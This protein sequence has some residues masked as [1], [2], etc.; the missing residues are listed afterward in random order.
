VK[1]TLTLRAVPRIGISSDT[2]SIT[3]FRH[4]DADPR[5]V[6]VTNVGTGTLSGL[7]VGQISYAAATTPGWLA[8]SFDSST[9][10]A[11]LTLRAA[12]QALP[13]G[14]FYATVPILSSSNGVADS[15]KLLTVALLVLSPP[16]GLYAVPAQVSLTWRQNDPAGGPWV[17]VAILPTG[18]GIVTHMGFPN[19]PPPYPYLWSQVALG[20]HDTEFTAPCTLQIRPITGSLSPGTYTGV[21][22]VKSFAQNVTVSVPV[23]L[24]VTP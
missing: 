4:N 21:V 20:C 11:H 9:A 14:T 6:L 1:A 16:P 7:S 12:S 8:A 5:S 24:T 19:S 2:V 18:D 3:V 15:P 17:D 23:T 10:P 13:S 22:T